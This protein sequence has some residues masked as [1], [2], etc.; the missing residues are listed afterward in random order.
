MKLLIVCLAVVLASA[1]GLFAQ[2][3]PKIISNPDPVYPVETAQLGYGGTVTV[4]VRVEKTGKGK[5]LRAWGPYAP[6]SKLGDGRVKKVRE[7][8]VQAANKMEFEPPVSDGKPAEVEVSV[9]YSFDSTG[10]PAKEK[11][12][13]GVKGRLSDL[14]LLA[15]RAR[16]L[17]KPAYP[18]G[19]RE[20]RVSGTVP[21]PP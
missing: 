7:G 13:S 4:V 3:A 21:I 15:K 19:A 16:H 9:S 18:P 8:V 11:D 12:P 1:V 6:C 17:A 14:G 2:Q 10:Q 20:N 5:V